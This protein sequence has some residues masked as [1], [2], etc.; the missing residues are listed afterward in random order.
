MSRAAAPSSISGTVPRRRRFRGG[1]VM[2]L[3]LVAMIDIVFLLLIFFLLQMRFHQPE[4]ILPSRLPQTQGAAAMPSEVPISPLRVVVRQTG[5]GPADYDIR[6]D[7]MP[8]PVPRNFGDLA[9]QLKQVQATDGYSD[10]TPV[11]I[12]PLG[13][14]KW[15][16]VVNAYNAAVRAAYKN[17]HFAANQ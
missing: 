4:G 5:P 1:E 11:V 9:T 8:P 17:I 16:H 13:R 10:E 7:R 12:M 3:N 6:I 2:S 14:V 15:D